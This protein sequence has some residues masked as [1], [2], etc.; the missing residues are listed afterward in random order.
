MKVDSKLNTL[1][2]TLI[3]LGL[4]IILMK[5]LLRAAPILIGIGVAVVAVGLVKRFI[6]GWRGGPGDRDSFDDRP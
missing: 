6:A 3:V 2:L 4:G 5:V 1:G